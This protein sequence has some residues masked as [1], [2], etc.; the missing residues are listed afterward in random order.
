MEQGLAEQM[1]MPQAAQSQQQGMPTVEEIIQMLMQGMDPQEMVNMGIPPE[2][3][4]QA[5][6][7]IEQQMVAQQVPAEQQGL[8]AQTV[9]GA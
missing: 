1:A 6:Q 5:I 9:M 2:L 3:I 7:I 8:A 4:M